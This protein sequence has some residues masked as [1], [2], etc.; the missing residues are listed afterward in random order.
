MNIS[1]FLLKESLNVLLVMRVSGRLFAQFYI[2]K[3]AQHKAKGAKY[4]EQNGRLSHRRDWVTGHQ[5]GSGAE[6]VGISG[7]WREVLPSYWYLKGTFLWD[8][9][10]VFHDMQKALSLFSAWGFK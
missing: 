8:V 6:E 4:A 10:L 7:L 1:S 9:S 3:K 2:Q 5:G